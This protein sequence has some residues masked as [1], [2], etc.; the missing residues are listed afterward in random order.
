MNNQNQKWKT[1]HGDGR[2][3]LDDILYER[4]MAEIAAERNGNNGASVRYCDCPELIINGER[5]PC[6]PYHDCAYAQTRSALV[7]V[8]EQRASEQIHVA[9]F[10]EAAGHK[11]TKIFA[12][13]VERLAAPLFR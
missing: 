8:A 5:V 13:E 9:P 10:D 2:K 7:L 3:S 12:A 1:Y 11:W 6:P 4:E